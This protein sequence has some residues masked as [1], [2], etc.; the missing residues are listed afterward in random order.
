MS[1]NTRDM[2]TLETVRR[3]VVRLLEEQGLNGAALAR[4]LDHST[5]WSSN[6]LT[7]KKTIPLATVQAIAHFLNVPT[8]QLLVPIS[9]DLSQREL[10]QG[11]GEIS[12][13]E[14]S[15]LPPRS[16]LPTAKGGQGMSHRH[17]PDPAA[18]LACLPEA[19]QD[20]IR[21]DLKRR[22]ARVLDADT[23]GTEVK[24]SAV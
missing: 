20:E 5:S 22:V 9:D 23:T 24:T 6:F 17:E 14:G 13:R 10:S 12:S 1:S 8:W 11:I 18:M 2:N 7:G 16:G 15:T 4:G 21:A 19:E 3:N